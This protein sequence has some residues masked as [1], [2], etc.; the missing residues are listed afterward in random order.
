M[1]GAHV[2]NESLIG[3]ALSL[4]TA[5]GSTAHLDNVGSFNPG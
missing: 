2:R 1:V 3:T 5:L 4:Q